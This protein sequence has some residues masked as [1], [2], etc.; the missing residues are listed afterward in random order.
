MSG[1]RAHIAGRLRSS[2]Q[3]LSAVPPRQE[4]PDYSP[5]LAKYAASILF[6]SPI[7]SQ[8]NRPVYILNAAALPDTKEEN[9]DS[10]LPYVLA[11]LP[12]EDE[13]VRGFE[14][15]VV[16][17]AGDS[18]GSTTSKKNRPGW[19]W[20]LQAYHVLSRAMRK[21][22]QKLYIVHE[23]AWVRILT[24]VFSTIVSPKFRRKIIHASDLTNLA[25]HIPIEDLLI[26]PS[27]YL[28]DRR[29]S[30]TI[31]APY[32]SGRR[33]FGARQPL[34]ISSQGT[35][36]LPR[37]LRETTAFVLAEQNIGAEGLF[38]VPPHSK[39][40]DVLKEAYDRGQK[41]IVWKDNGALLQL[42]PYP[43][44]ELQ[45]EIIAE[46]DARDAYSAFMAAA[47]I[48]AW[49]ADLRQ[50]IFPQSCYGELKRLYG[51]P[52][53]IPDLERL[54]E[55]FSPVS[56]W[57]FLPAISREILTKHL[58]PT[59]NAVAAREEQNKMTAENLAVCI[60]PALLHGPDQLED[61]K[62]SSIV[63][64]IFTEAIELWSHG[65]REACGENEAA[66]RESLELPRSQSD[67]ED[68]LERVKGA[69]EGRAWDENHSTGIVLQDN[70]KPAEI[71][72]A[73]PPRV[74]IASGRAPNDN[75]TKRKPAPP[76]EV[77]PRYSTL[78]TDSP[79]DASPVSYG[80]TTDGFA[81]RRDEPNPSAHFP[82]E[83]KSGTSS[84]DSYAPQLKLPKRKSLTAEQIDNA[85]TAI[86]Q[87]HARKASEE[88]EVQTRAL[89]PSELKGSAMPLPG[90]ANL[91][92]AK[93]GAAGPAP[94]V[95]RKAVSG[96]YTT[97]QGSSP[98]NATSTVAPS[99]AFPAPFN[100]FR[101]PSLPA[102]ANRTPQINTL[103][104]PVFPTNPTP[105]RP[106]S[107]STSLPVPA[108]K[109]RTP[110][111]SLLQRMPSFETSKKE[112]SLAPPDVPRRLNMKKT[113]VDD[114]RRL[115][116]ERAG[117]A[118]VL[119]EAGRKHSS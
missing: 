23:K 104:R 15:E 89:R 49:Y 66:F 59:L 101:R 37:V 46:I 108:P 6:R 57:S 112:Q 109:P 77:P 64:R 61:A 87:V 74:G 106:P 65:L 80:A 107:K 97:S 35:P 110:S 41:Y 11:R 48:K 24:E 63:R 22:L 67:W 19:G 68:P 88:M 27:T 114:L 98:T 29:V 62:M 96:A 9:F 116:E 20:F 18:D 7:P 73:L 90:L 4:S 33:A 2:S 12:E 25:L 78:V 60:A 14:Y 71:P 13:L 45:D 117:T 30:E 91:S 118:S 34:P 72:P 21:R 79:I 52:D 5:E 47:L 119:V 31:Y 39:L 10:L 84:G 53:D 51:N 85:D 86:A 58:L 93:S 36:R 100:D 76:L 8:E 1:L 28:Y 81:P 102:S 26:P 3:S 105:N 99:T 50:P 75:A 38:R 56:E 115:Y 94:P 92:I 32:A 54:K 95:K 111:P 17:F 103:A 70:E 16:F 83:K 42:P 44:A 82:D 69:E 113:S 55:L 40:R 43:H